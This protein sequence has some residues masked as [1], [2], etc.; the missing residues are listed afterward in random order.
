MGSSSRNS[1]KRKRTFRGNKFSK[2]HKDNSAKVSVNSENSSDQHNLGASYRKLIGKIIAENNSENNSYYILFYVQS[3]QNLLAMV[4]CT[5]CS[6]CESMYIV[7]DNS[8]RKGW[9]SRLALCCKFCG[10]TTDYVYTSPKQGYSFEVNRRMVYGMRQIGC[11]YAEAKTFS[12]VMNMPPPPNPN[13]FHN[14]TK[15]LSRVVSQIAEESMKTEADEVR[16]LTGKG[17]CG[18]S[19]DGAG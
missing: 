6:M 5:E 18:V 9:A 8:M 12:L 4:A 7:C 14:H 16:E 11:V 17:E 15:V 3:L 2:V 13:A 19:E 10:H 1:K